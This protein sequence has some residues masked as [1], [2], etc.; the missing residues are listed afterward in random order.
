MTKKELNKM[1][2]KEILQK[3][4]KELFNE[5]IWNLSQNTFS[6]MGKNEFNNDYRELQLQNSNPTPY[7]PNMNHLPGYNK[8]FRK[9]NNSPYEILIQSL[10][11]IK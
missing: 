1:T 2:N 4:P 11:L 6:T 5:F 10:S 3:A 8:D 9:S 7:N